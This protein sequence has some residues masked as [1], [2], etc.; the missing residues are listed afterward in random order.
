MPDIEHELKEIFDR[1]SPDVRI[2]DRIY[3]ALREAISKGLLSPGT[4]L[5][6][7]K[8]ASLLNVSRTPV[9]EAIQRLQQDGFLVS[10]DAKK[11]V[12]N[13][14]GVKDIEDIYD[15]RIGLEGTAARLAA[16]RATEIDIERLEAVLKTAR[17][18]IHNLELQVQLNSQ[19]HNIIA[20][21]T[22]N[23]RL[24][25]LISLYHDLVQT[26]HYT[27]LRYP[28]RV[29]EAISE[30][31]LILKAIKE[32]NENL[33]MENAIKHMENARRVRIKLM[34]ESRT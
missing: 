6:E 8:I 10:S 4:G 7:R 33:A 30:H 21:S 28:G 32:R 18:N 23:V 16:R 26:V 22:R 3:S 27:S 31:E 13:K 29:E 9:R 34:L 14:P 11:I 25:C 24:R 12:V 5:R 2:S 19:F 15:I 1:Y 20:E 17:K